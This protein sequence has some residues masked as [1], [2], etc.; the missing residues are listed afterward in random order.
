MIEKLFYGLIIACLVSVQSSDVIAMQ[1]EQVAQQPGWSAKTICIYAGVTLTLLLAASSLY[2]GDVDHIKSSAH[3]GL[4][5]DCGNGLVTVFV[6]GSIPVYTS[7]IGNKLLINGKKIDCPRGTRYA[8]YDNE[9]L[10][11]ESGTMGQNTDEDG[12]V[13]VGGRIFVNGQEIDPEEVGLSP[14]KSMKCTGGICIKGDVHLKGS[15][16]SGGDVHVIRERKRRK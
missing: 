14:K 3:K 6:Q 11:L 15:T 2:S 4:V 13:F 5:V 7:V 9:G 1:P 10:E 8:I 16:I 12:R